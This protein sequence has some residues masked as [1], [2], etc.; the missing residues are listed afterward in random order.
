MVVAEFYSLCPQP[1]VQIGHELHEEARCV[2]D[3]IGKN[4][5]VTQFVNQKEQDI[6]LGAGC[7]ESAD[8]DPCLRHGTIARCKDQ[9]A[10][11]V[12]SAALARHLYSQARTEKWNHERSYCAEYYHALILYRRP[13]ASWQP[14]VILGSAGQPKAFATLEGTL[15]GTPV[16]SEAGSAPQESRPFCGRTTT[17]KKSPCNSLRNGVY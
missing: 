10:Q 15:E 1:V 6:G 2:L 13:L 7:P 8:P 12:E 3:P 16:S 17:G 5:R 4:R 11:P 9:G 14:E